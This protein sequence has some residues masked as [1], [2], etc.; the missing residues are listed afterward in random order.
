MIRHFVTF[1]ARNSLT[2][3]QIQWKGLYGVCL[4]GVRRLNS[5][6]GMFGFRGCSRD[7]SEAISSRLKDMFQL[8]CQHYES[9]GEENGG[10]GKGTYTHTHLD[11]HQHAY[12]QTW[13]R[14][15][16]RTHLWMHTYN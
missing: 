9:K 16:V 15:Y 4:P 13:N 10:L 6:A 7:P 12:P 14:Q 11:T 5:L 8:F 1:P 3:V 2:L